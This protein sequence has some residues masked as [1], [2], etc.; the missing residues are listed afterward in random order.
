M[1]G[2]VNRG[3]TLEKE[4]H[5]EA[6]PPFQR[7]LARRSEDGSY[8]NAGIDAVVYLSDRHVATA[9]SAIYLPALVIFGPTLE[10]QPWKIEVINLILGRWAAWNG[11]PI[12][13]EGV[14]SLDD[15]VTAEHVP[16]TMKLHETWRPTIRVGHT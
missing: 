6:D 10:D 5:Q 7:E 8:R 13:P 9:G 2:G 1:L 4:G 16:D 15:M 3:S 14:V 11:V 12:R